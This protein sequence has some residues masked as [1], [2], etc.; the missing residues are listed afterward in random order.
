M[1]SETK[2][3]MGLIAIFA[4]LMWS[5]TE[6]AISL[7][8]ACYHFLVDKIK[9]SSELETHASWGSIRKIKQWV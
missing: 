7:R 9:I 6:P 3:F 2:N 5:A 4:Q 1:Q 8:S